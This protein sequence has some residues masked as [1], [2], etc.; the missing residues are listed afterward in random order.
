MPNP[1]DLTSAES[2]KASM[3]R[4]TERRIAA[5]YQ[6]W[7]E[8]LGRRAEQFARNPSRS[9]WVQQQQMR[10]LQGELEAKARQIGHELWVSVQQ[11]ALRV[12][13]SVVGANTEWLSQLGMP[14]SGLS[15]VSVPETVLRSI[16]SGQVYSGNWSLSQSI[17][18]DLNQT[19]GDISNIIAG[20]IAK[21]DGIYEI[22]RE[23][24]QYVKPG[25]RKGWKGPR[26]KDGRLIRLYK[27]EVDYNAQRLARTMSQHAYQRALV[28]TCRDNPFIQKFIWWANGSRVCPKCE[29][30]NGREFDVDKLP[31]DHPNGMC[32]IEPKV[33]GNVEDRLREWLLSEPGTFPDIDRFA[34]TL[35]MVW[36]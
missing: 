2:L 7:S 17:W 14:T 1:F 25:A 32:V 28:E 36:G 20:G 34:G 30:M 15:F 21:N 9:A 19:L 16:V 12:A 11:D 26:D 31:L 13:N 10:Q 23:L 33:D 24:E 35:G 27:G 22:A 6:Q 3:V 5:L 4:E 8:D 29:E 18:R